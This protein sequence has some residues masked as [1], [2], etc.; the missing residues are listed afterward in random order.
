MINRKHDVTTRVIALLARAFRLLGT[1]SP[2][3][4][5]R[6]GASSDGCKPTA[7]LVPAARAEGSA[8]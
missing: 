4:C 3:E 8:V 1:G 5:N 2:R 6:L 7:K